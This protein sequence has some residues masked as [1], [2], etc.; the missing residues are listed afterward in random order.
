MQK[1][2]GLFCEI[3][4]S[5]PSP[6][7]PIPGDETD[8]TERLW[9]HVLGPS[10]HVVCLGSRETLFELKGAL[11]LGLMLFDLE[12]GPRRAERVQVLAETCT[13]RPVS[14]DL[15][16]QLCLSSLPASSQGKG[17]AEPPGF[18]LSQKLMS[19]FT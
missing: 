8:S 16:A 12:E 13:G 10:A 18:P 11:F 3:I 19:H 1:V 14:S 6:H 2:L 17:Q 5:A 4:R 9:P 7:P 15:A